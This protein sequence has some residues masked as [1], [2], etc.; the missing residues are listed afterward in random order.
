MSTQGRRLR[1]RYNVSYNI[2]ITGVYDEEHDIESDATTAQSHTTISSHPGILPFNHAEDEL[3]TLTLSHAEDE[4]D[5]E[6]F[7]NGDNFDNGHGN[8]GTVSEEDTNDED[9][10][11]VPD[12][13]EEEATDDMCHHMDDTAPSLST[14]RLLNPDATSSD[15]LADVKLMM[16]ALFTD[17]PEIKAFLRKLEKAPAKPSSFPN[18][19]K[20]PLTWADVDPEIDQ[21]RDECIDNRPEIRNPPPF[22]TQD[23]A[24]PVNPFGSFQAKSLINSSYPTSAP[25]SSLLMEYATVN[26][27]T[28]MCM[29][30]LYAKPG[31]YRID[32]RKAD[33]L[34]LD[35]YPVRLDRNKQDA[36]EPIS[37]LPAKVRNYW[38]TRHADRTKR[39]KAKIIIHVGNTTALQYQRHI[40]HEGLDAVAIGRGDKECALKRLPICWKLYTTTLSGLRE[41]T[42]IKINTPHPEGFIPLQAYQPR[43]RTRSLALRERLVDSALFT[44]YGS[45][46]LTTFLSTI[47]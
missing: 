12:V 1:K 8:N 47:K 45:F 27:L 13:A 24:M 41:L 40:Q 6:G 31:F 29:F 34:H 37:R 20:E 42:A 15:I 30:K 36:R 9:G 17:L 10:I 2:D 46:L 5:F 43:A 44:V 14:E 19:E 32:L 11:G 26:N 33:I 18:I 35:I 39:S 25:R 21:H 28:N 38:E 16:P 7:S 4:T 22:M 3:D 23:P